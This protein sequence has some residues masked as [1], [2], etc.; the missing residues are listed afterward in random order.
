MHVPNDSIILE[1]IHLQRRIDQEE[2]ARP[3]TTMNPFKK[4]IAVL[5]KELL[6]L[7]EA[8]LGA[9]D[10]PDQTTPSPK[11]IEPSA[12]DE[13]GKSRRLYEELSALNCLEGTRQLRALQYK[14]RNFLDV[15]NRQLSSNEVT[16]S[17]YAAAGEQLYLA[18]LDNL[19][20]AAVALRS[21]HTINAPQ[22]LA[23]LNENSDND[24]E[25]KPLQQRL[26]TQQEQSARVAE[27]LSQN[28]NALTALD[29]AAARLAAVKMNRGHAAVDLN[30]AMEELDRL[31]KWAQR[32]A[33]DHEE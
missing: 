21:I 5:Y 2:T 12:I 13:D 8:I 24:E 9:A 10:A 14:Y 7:K 18:A 1:P 25:Q 31:A 3:P 15:L 22:L 20:A 33:L 32:Y 6:E 4:I 16:F 19:N 29:Q 17:R 28:E 27:G 11:P 30:T 26:T 23:R